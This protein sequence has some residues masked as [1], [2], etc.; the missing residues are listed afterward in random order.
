VEVEEAVLESRADA[1]KLTNMI[2]AGFGEIRCT[3]SLKMG[4]VHQR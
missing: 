1:A 3:S 2:I 4:G